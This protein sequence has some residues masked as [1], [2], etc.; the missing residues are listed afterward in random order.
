MGLDHDVCYRAL[1][2][3]DARFDGRFFVA[4]RTTGVY[5]R[6]ICPARTPKCE[7]IVFFPSAAAAQEAGFRPCLRCRPENSPDLASWNGTSNTVSRALTLIAGGALDESAVDGLAGRLG[8]GERQLRR[9][10][11]Q[12]LGVS[13]LAVAQTRRVLFAKQ[14]IAD[15]R[16]PLAEVAFASGFGSVRRFNTTFHQ[17]FRRP[18]RELR[19]SHVQAEGE[20]PASAGIMITLP[21]APPYD[22]NAMLSFLSARAIPGVEIV[23]NNCYRRTI[24]LD[25]ACGTVEVMLNPRETA[26][27]ATIHFPHVSA[28]SAIAGRLRRIFDLSA[29]PV[30]IGSHLSA[31]LRLAALV[32]ARPGL[33][34]PGAWDGFE[35]AVRAMLGQ[36]ITVGAATK[37]AGKLVAAH[38]E[39]FPSEGGLTHVFPHPEKLAGMDLRRLG[40]PSNRASALSSLAAA[41]AADP[42]LLHHCARG[43]DDS[44]LRLRA[45]PGIGEWTAQY[46]AMRA[47]REPDAFPASDIGLLRAMANGNGL[48]PTPLHLLAAAERWRPWRAYAA[49]HLWFSERVSDAL[50]H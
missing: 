29:D 39:P 50:H 23:E 31:D 8:V 17:L 3:R 41:F 21:F 25:S 34:V 36:Q 5:C 45:L 30:A 4:V 24:S 16:M 20:A 26:L 19:R 28:L 15:T 13:P 35:L 7:N 14:L 37:L 12:H 46:I 2:A 42:R 47:L 22:W 33:R 6:P 40:M 9:L 10:F 43:L 32:A 38:G 44:I 49:L 18:P 48:R 11:Q 27:C 1:K